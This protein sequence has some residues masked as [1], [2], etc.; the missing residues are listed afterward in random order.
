MAPSVRMSATDAGFLYVDRPHAPLQIASLLLLERPVGVDELV[1]RVESRLWRIPRY[2]QRAM[3]VPLALGHPSWEPSPDFDARD[4]IKR[5]ALPSPGG[6]HELAELAARLLE[7]PLQ[8]DRP[9]W[10]MHAIEGC[11]DGRAAL[12]IKVHH[13]MV[14]GLS[15][16]RLLDQ[17]LDTSRSPQSDARAA[18]P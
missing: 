13:C 11:H 8:R 16:V 18:R 10:E 7:Q 1:S 17:I 15:G 4:H 5:W 6:E 3:S 14:D 9:L 2:A 12:L